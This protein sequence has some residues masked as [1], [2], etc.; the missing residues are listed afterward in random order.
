MSAAFDDMRDMRMDGRLFQRYMSQLFPARLSTRPVW[1]QLSR[2]QG[3]IEMKTMT[4]KQP[5]GACNQE[6]RAAALSGI[7]GVALVR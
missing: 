1:M 4:C 3:E 6:F 7:P 2:R 5:G